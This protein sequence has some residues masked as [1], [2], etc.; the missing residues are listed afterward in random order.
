MNLRILRLCVLI[1][2]LL[3][4]SAASF[5]QMP[6]GGITVSTFFNGTTYS[7]GTVFTENFGNV[8]SNPSGQPC[9]TGGT[10]TAAQCQ[11]LWNVTASSGS[12][13]IVSAPSGWTGNALKMASN[14][15][16]VSMNTVGTFPAIPAS[17]GIVITLNIYLS[18]NPSSTTTLFQV[19]RPDLGGNLAAINANS[20]GFEWT[21][22]GTF[23]SAAAATVHTLIITLNG[24]SSTFKIDGTEC[25]AAATDPGV[26]GGSVFLDGGTG[27][28]TYVQS[29]TIT[30]STVTGG[31]PPNVLMDFAEQSGNTVNATN[32]QAGTHCGNAFSGTSVGNRQASSLIGVSFSFVTDGQAFPSPAKVCSTNYPGTSNVALEMAVPSSAGPS[33]DWAA[34]FF[35]TVYSNAAVGLFVKI[36]AAGT[37]GSLNLDWISTSSSSAVETMQFH[38]TGSGTAF[39]LCAENNTG[40]GTAQCTTNA[41]TGGTWYWVGMNI[42]S[43]GANIIWLYSASGTFIEQKSFSGT[44]EPFSPGSYAVTLGKTG[45]ETMSN[46]SRVEYSNVVTTYANAPITAFGPY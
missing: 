6:M 24:S 15:T 12:Q 10:G 39:T 20:T 14:A 4:F 46:S 35:Q 32:L 26:V 37:L 19:V 17:S 27:F 33:G 28:D 2:A 11:Q 8:T 25:G 36:T 5:A 13:S 43:T 21:T 38:D 30:G 9:W 23:C 31:W 7:T 22:N 29:L 3:G 45:G 44:A 16:S 1:I 40:G 42:T 18:A 41:L 34:G